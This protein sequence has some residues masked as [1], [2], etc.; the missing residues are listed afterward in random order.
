MGPRT[1]RELTVALAAAEWSRPQEAGL[2]SRIRRLRGGALQ[3]GDAH[4]GEELR[5]LLQRLALGL[6]HEHEDERKVHDVQDPEGVES[7]HGGG[8]HHEGRDHDHGRVGQVVQAHRDG[9]GLLLLNHGEDLRGV[10]PRDCPPSHL[11]AHTI[12]DYADHEDEAGQIELQGD[13]CEHERRAHDARCHQELAPAPADAGIHEQ[14][15]Q[16]ATDNHDAVEDDIKQQ[17]IFDASLCEDCS[18]ITKEGIDSCGLLPKH[19]GASDENTLAK[20]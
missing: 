9:H 18:R 10:D 5:D 4:R 17:V 6:H 8:R 3:G 20:V 7:A 16:S 15:T 2:R 11:E 13:G 19:E 14:E 1:H 12:Q